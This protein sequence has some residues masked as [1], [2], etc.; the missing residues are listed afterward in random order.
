MENAGLPIAGAPFA[1]DV[2]YA[3]GKDATEE[4]SNAKEKDLRIPPDSQYEAP[5]V[6]PRTDEIPD[7][8]LTAWLTVL[9][10][11][12]A[13]FATLGSVA[14]FGVF[15]SQYEAVLPSKSSGAISWITAIQSA[16]VTALAVPSVLFSA[17]VGPHKA[18]ATGTFFIVVR[19]YYSQTLMHV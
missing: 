4:D 11:S 10:C 3:A 5:E 7:G 2:P 6:Q 12:L 17:H 19:V 15:Q 1:N 16:S 14:S 8:G 18:L 13:F 9:G